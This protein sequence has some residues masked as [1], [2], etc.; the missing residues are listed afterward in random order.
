MYVARSEG[1]PDINKW[2]GD[3]VGKNY[4]GDRMIPDHFCNTVWRLENHLSA[5]VCTFNERPAVAALLLLGLPPPRPACWCIDC[6]AP[7]TC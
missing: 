5:L 4:V 3:N 7:C 2:L 1:R 6:V